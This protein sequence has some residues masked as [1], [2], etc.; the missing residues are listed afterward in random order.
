[1]EACGQVVENIPSS[2][3]MHSEKVVRFLS[4]LTKLYIDYCFPLD[5]G[6]SE[7]DILVAIFRKL[8]VRL[9]A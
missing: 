5:I 1:M 3:E 7:M 4:W 6:K 9:K 2:I 8:I